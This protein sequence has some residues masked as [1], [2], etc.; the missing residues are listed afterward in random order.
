MTF[1]DTNVIIDIFDRKREDHAKALLLLSAAQ[2][3]AIKLAATTQSI[4]DAAY[5]IT[6][7]GKVPLKVF[8]QAM[9]FLCDIIQIYPVLSYDIEKANG[10]TIPDYEDAVQLSCAMGE[11]FDCIVTRDKKFKGFT[12]IPTYTVE[13]YYQEVFG[14]FIS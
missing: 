11:E 9:S 10:S 5:V 12:T 8:R 4:V 3:G 13:E 1:L 7:A 6:Q 2:K 14:D